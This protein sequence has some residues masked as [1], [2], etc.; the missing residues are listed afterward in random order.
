[1]KKT[2]KNVDGEPTVHTVN[3]VDT[4]TGAL[5]VRKLKK[6]AP[7][8][9]GF[10]LALANDIFELI[11]T[12]QLLW[13][14]GDWRHLVWE[15]DLEPEDAKTLR[16]MLSIDKDINE[17]ACGTAM[18]F[19]GWVNEMTGADWVLDRHSAKDYESIREENRG[20]RTIEFVLVN[21]TQRAWF[22]D[23]GQGWWGDLATYLSAPVLEKIG[24]RGFTPKTHWVT[25]T[26]SFAVMQLG[27]VDGDWLELFEG[28]N[29]L[30]MIRKIID[31]YAEH[32]PV[33]N[34]AVKEAY[35]HYGRVPTPAEVE[36]LAMDAANL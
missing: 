20:D 9:N 13:D 24:R 28:S 30:S 8:E 35:E 36:R 32:G 14:Q 29:E 1:M 7:L 15:S 23:S 12:N 3:G 6:Y 18:C 27:L 33:H 2:I 19:A 22:Y 21:K 34:D 16:T 31:T 26:E 17:P 25:D 10:N 11:S 5:Y 4:K